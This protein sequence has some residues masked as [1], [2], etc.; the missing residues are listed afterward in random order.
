[1]KIVLDSNILLVAIGKRSR[2]RPI[3]DAFTDG[4]YKLVVCEEVIYEYEE[5]LSGYGFIRC[6]QSHLVNK[7]FV[8]SWMKEDGDHLLLFNGKA[9][10][11]SRTKKDLVK[12]GLDL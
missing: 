1:M 5:I 3:W 2:F 8:K 12:K 10:P 4:K 6:H 7:K 11:I 9:V